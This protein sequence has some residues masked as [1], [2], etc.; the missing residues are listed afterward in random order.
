MKPVS[1]TSVLT[2]EANCCFFFNPSGKQGK[3]S[4]NSYWCYVN[5]NYLKECS[6][7]KLILLKPNDLNLISQLS[8]I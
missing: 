7:G 4:E 1:Y 3:K 8:T 5:I 2:R 6:L